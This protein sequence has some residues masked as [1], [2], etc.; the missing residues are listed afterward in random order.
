MPKP[1]VNRVIPV[2][3]GFKSGACSLYGAIQI[4]LRVCNAH[5]AGFELAGGDIDPLLKHGPEEFAESRGA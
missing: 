5:E 3:K 1:P 2:S 4:V